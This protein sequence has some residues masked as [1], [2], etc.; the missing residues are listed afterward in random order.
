[1]NSEEQTILMF[2]PDGKCVKEILKLQGWTNCMSLLHDKYLAVG[3]NAGRISVNQVNLR[4]GTKLVPLKVQLQET[5]WD[6]IALKS[7]NY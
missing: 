5:S 3:T 1:M 4:H 6:A 7:E 2:S